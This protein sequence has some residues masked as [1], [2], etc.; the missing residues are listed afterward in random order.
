MNYYEQVEIKF[1]YNNIAKYYYSKRRYLLI[2]YLRL[3]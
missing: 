3:L 2:F 1:N